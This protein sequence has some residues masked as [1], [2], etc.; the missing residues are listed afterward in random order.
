MDALA[1]LML[2][3]VLIFFFSDKEVQDIPVDTSSSA[4]M[5][6]SVADPHVMLLCIDGSVL[7]MYLEEDFN[8][9]CLKLQRPDLDQVRIKI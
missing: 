4:I 8:G 7:Y 5:Y 3:L 2:L 6:A 1:Q 9:A